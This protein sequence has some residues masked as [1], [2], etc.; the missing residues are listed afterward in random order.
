MSTNTRTYE[1]DNQNVNFYNAEKHKL[2]CWKCKVR[3]TCFKENIAIESDDKDS[4]V[5]LDKPCVDAILTMDLIDLAD[6]LEAP[7]EFI[8]K[9][10]LATLFNDA[11][12]A[13]DLDH[14]STIGETFTQV[15][16]AMFIRIVQRDPNY[17]HNGYDTAYYRL[18]NLFVSVFKDFDNAI[19]LYSRAINLTTQRGDAYM[20][21]GYCWL[22]KNDSE[23]ALADFRKA[24]QIDGILTHVHYQS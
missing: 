9:K 19:D 21:R 5:T 13:C 11:L 20:K 24:I 12:Y 10:D 18:G 1:I 8:D 16:Y 4:T 22:E 7:I 14:P 2:P 3:E 6:G 15:G 23:K 17:V